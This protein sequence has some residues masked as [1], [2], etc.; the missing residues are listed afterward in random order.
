MSSRARIRAQE[1]DDD[2][3]LSRV[4]SIH[5]P[6][7]SNPKQWLR[8]EN[9]DLDWTFTV[10]TARTWS[11]D[12]LLTHIYENA[13]SIPPRDY[14]PSA[15]FVYIK[16]HNGETVTLPHGYRLPLAFVAKYCWEMTLSKLK[17]EKA[18]KKERTGIFH[19]ARL[20]E[21][22]LQRAR[23]KAFTGGMEKGW[24][25]EMFDRLLARFYKQRTRN[26]PQGIKEFVAKF[27]MKEYD[28]DVLKH[29][30]KRWCMRGITGIKMQE[31]EVINGLTIEGLRKTLKKGQDGV[32]SIDD[33]PLTYVNSEEGDS[34]S[35]T[36]ELTDFDMD[37][38]DVHEVDARGEVIA[39]GGKNGTIPVNPSTVGSTDEIIPKR[40]RDSEEE[41]E[42][43]LLKRVRVE[44]G[45]PES[46][47]RYRFNHIYPLSRTLA[48]M[49]KNPIWSRDTE[50]L[51]AP[52]AS[53]PVA[54]GSWT[55]PTSNLTLMESASTAGPSSQRLASQSGT[56]ESDDEIVILP[57]PPKSKSVERRSASVKSQQKSKMI[58]R[59]GSELSI[60]AL[61]KKPPKPRQTRAAQIAGVATVNEYIDEGK[62]LP[63]G[64][65]PS[66][67]STNKWQALPPPTS[68]K[69]WYRG[70]ASAALSKKNAS[71]G[72]PTSS[73]K[74][75]SS[76]PTSAPVQVSDS[77]L[78]QAQNPNPADPN[79][80]RD[81]GTA[82]G[83]ANSSV[84][85]ENSQGLTLLPPPAPVS[86]SQLPT[87]PNSSTAA[88][89]VSSSQNFGPSSASPLPPSLST[90]QNTTKDTVTAGPVPTPTLIVTSPNSI[91]TEPM[92][93][94]QPE[95]SKS[96]TQPPSNSP[97][98]S[99]PPPAHPPSKI[100]DTSAIPTTVAPRSSSSSSSITSIPVKPLSAVFDPLPTWRATLEQ[101]PLVEPPS[102]Q[103]QRTP[104]VIPT[105]APP[106]PPPS[107]VAPVAQNDKPSDVTAKALELLVN[108]IDAKQVLGDKLPASTCAS[109]FASGSAASS[110][111]SLR[112]GASQGEGQEALE[113]RFQDLDGRIT[114]VKEELQGLHDRLLS[115]ENQAREQRTASG[116][117]KE[118][119]SMDVI[120]GQLGCGESGKEPGDVEM[121]GPEPGTAEVVVNSASQ[122]YQGGTPSVD[123]T[124]QAGVPLTP[125]S[126]PGPLSLSRQG[127]TGEMQ[128]TDNQS[129]IG[130]EADTESTTVN[131]NNTMTSLASMIPKDD[132]A[133]VRTREMSSNLS[134]FVDNLVSAKMLALME[135][136]AKS[137][138][139]DL[140]G[141]STTLSLDIEQC[142]RNVS[143]TAMVPPHPPPPPAPSADPFIIANL[144]DELRALKGEMR[145]KERRE[146]Q[147]M[148][149]MRRLHVAEVDALRR[150]LS[151]LESQTRY[152]ET[153]QAQAQSSHGH[154]GA[155]GHHGHGQG[156]SLNHGH[157]SGSGSGMAN[158]RSSSTHS[159]DRRKDGA[160]TP[161]TVSERSYAFTRPEPDEL[162]LPIKSQRKNLSFPR[163]NYG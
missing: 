9:G 79:D 145:D 8:D 23:A 28:R 57:G 44:G 62:P 124:R 117:G 115:F 153:Q 126:P 21:N 52:V 158:H 141:S 116:K 1:E 113:A 155:G 18:W 132:V 149:E 3:E 87:T 140:V 31:E 56:R 100:S 17:D 82:A 29:D 6:V 55:G 74:S 94:P 99:V 24:R 13:F 61:A 2:A 65:S 19:L 26:D 131:N 48:A 14:N 16:F 34:W 80:S 49:Q 78:F 75:K 95:G 68:S 85:P 107:V 41:E 128:P 139:K 105:P 38:A 12:A 43:R 51:S 147:E 42:A 86:S 76:P 64:S 84:G 70:K 59:S 138:V 102:M 103:R 91:P 119:E 27:G 98:P 152:F 136:M 142:D 101:P 71:A 104:T 92:Q 120:G 63:S 123:G 97:K 69:P 121:G 114:A 130:S 40:E 66:Q 46:H 72:P 45:I 143:P 89:A 148:E 88:G 60:S 162:P 11:H 160:T 81:D 112:Q 110:Y 111:S 109:S 127:T 163:P 133:D 35:T 32:W 36:S 118:R 159:E 146:R 54:S 50:S 134:L 7:N 77:S 10:E 108:L 37:E 151:Y 47:H 15:P 135:G 20:C 106:P 161:S 156:H 83:A 53:A 90:P 122:A 39:P 154:G 67:Q 73:N 150:R 25:C 125:G 58:E 137:K 144:V 22:L 4:L 93:Q 96:N 30:W 157:A 33:Q 129:G 5:P